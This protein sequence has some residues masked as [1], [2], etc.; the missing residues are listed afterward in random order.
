[1]YL[2]IGIDVD[3]EFKELKRKVEKAYNEMNYDNVVVNLPY[4]IS[5]KISFE[6]GNKLDEIVNDLEN[7]FKSYKPFT[8]ET[9]SIEN[10]KTICWIRYKDN[11]KISKIKEDVNSLLFNKYNI[12]YHEY[13]LDF[14]FH[15]TLFLD[16]DT[17]KVNEFYEKVKDFSIPK[18]LTVNR[19]LIG[20]SLS[21]DP[22]TYS[23]I[24][25]IEW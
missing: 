8:V 11:E 15:T 14:I 10:E 7:L 12:P 22:G 5:L 21:G 16:S 20:T 2:W 25:K 1:M 6:A 9:L 13:D 18:A 24:R 23:I 17:S 4:H 3:S 19:F